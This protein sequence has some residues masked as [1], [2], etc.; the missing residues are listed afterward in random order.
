MKL[1]IFSL[2]AVFAVLAFAPAW[3]QGLPTARPERVGLEAEQLSKITTM[4]RMD[5]DAGRTVGSIAA[6]VRDGKIAYFDTAGMAD[7]ENNVPMTD[8]TIFRIYSMTKPI[9]STALMTLYEDGLF[10][11]RDPV[12]KYLPELGGLQVLVEKKAV[13]GAPPGIV[14]RDGSAGRPPMP[15]ASTYTTEPATRDM[16]IQD[17]MR[18]TAGLT[19][20]IFGN[21]S[22]DKIYRHHGILGDHDL[23]E[24]I[25]DLGK[26]P[27]QYQPGTRWH[28]S[29]SVDVQGAL[30]EVLS[31]MHLDKF[32]EARMFEPLGMVDTGF[33]VPA[34]KMDRFAQMYVPG[35]ENTLEIANPA[36]SRNFM[37]RPTFFGGGGGLVSTTADYLRFCQMHLNGGELEGTRILGRKTVELMRTDHLGEVIRGNGAYGFG[38][39][40]AVAKDQGRIGAVGSVGEYNWGGAAG[41][42]FW[43]DPVENM[44]GIYMIQILPGSGLPYGNLFK[45]YAYQSIVD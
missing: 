3:G 13:T 12:S 23:R 11:L 8:D 20:G 36:L 31:G 10:Q 33:F 42:K 9:V 17:L 1:R 29:V 24:F 40:F 45:N 37:Q 18:H 41:T 15:D 14:P 35:K 5:V 44:I 32:L 26:A 27:L 22:V 21:T 7:R 30:I 43:I 34:E 4:M 19:Y 39:G 6:V 38:L 25:T 16:T 2:V 28:Y